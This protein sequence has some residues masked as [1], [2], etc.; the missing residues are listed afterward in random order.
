MNAIFGRN[1][2]SIMLAESASKT[3]NYDY[4]ALWW[5]LSADIYHPITRHDIES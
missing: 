1:W 5:S 2:Q 4:S 3:D